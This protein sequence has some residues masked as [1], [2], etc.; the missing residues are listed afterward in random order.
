MPRPSLRHLYDEARDRD[1]TVEEKAGLPG[2]LRMRDAVTL[3]AV[4]SSC[5]H[6]T[7]AMRLGGAGEMKIHNRHQRLVRATSDQVAAL[8]AD[9]DAIWPTQIAPAPRDEV[10][11]G[12]VEAALLE[13]EAVVEAAVAGVPDREYGERIVAWVVVRSGSHVT[14]ETLADYAAARLSATSVRRRSR[15]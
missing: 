5:R 13:H 12:E 11:A 6:G 9:F 8:V 2:R 1:V 15:S 7:S 10:G 14:A 4:R 3:A